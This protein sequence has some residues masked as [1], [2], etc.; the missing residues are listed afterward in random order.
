MET[1][2]PTW[3]LLPGAASGPDVW[4]RQRRILPA[5]TAFSYP[6]PQGGPLLEEYAAAVRAA[7]PPPYVL[8]GH[9]LGGAVAQTLAWDHPEDVVGLALVGTGPHLPVNPE[10]LAGLAAH[11]QEMLERIAGWSLAR[12]ADPRLRDECRRRMGAASPD[13]AWQQFQACATFD[14]RGRGT[15]PPVPV[16]ALVGSLDRMTPPGLV[17]SLAE[18][19]PATPV[20]HV[21]DA[22]HL[23]MLE[24]PEAANAWLADRRAE[25]G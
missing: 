23:V 9:S 5:A 22:G 19:W 6:P 20:H 1:S 8:V 17:E 18:V 7:L 4:S 15:P 3:V 10:L 14:L 2:Q 25:W 24:R 13:I 11:P 21:P 12:G 16:R